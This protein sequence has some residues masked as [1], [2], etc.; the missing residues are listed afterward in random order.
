MATRYQINEPI[1]GEILGVRLIQ[2]H[3]RVQIPKAVRGILQIKDGDCVYWV[4]EEGRVVL[5]KAGKRG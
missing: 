5:R 1:K 2:N 4:E 3:G